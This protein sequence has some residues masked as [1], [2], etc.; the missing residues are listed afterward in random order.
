MSVCTH[1][2]IQQ[3]SNTNFCLPEYS[4][5]HY[6]NNKPCI[7][8]F[9]SYAVAKETFNSMTRCDKVQTWCNKVYQFY[10]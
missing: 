3:Q 7:S 5:K 10:N 6:K 8:R 1:H 9:E 4:M 2:S